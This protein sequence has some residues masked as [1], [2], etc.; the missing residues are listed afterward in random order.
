MHNINVNSQTAY[1]PSVEKFF[2]SFNYL[3]RPELRLKEMQFAFRGLSRKFEK[4]VTVNG[5]IVEVV[6]GEYNWK[7]IL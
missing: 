5:A 4:I 1:T 2:A 3:A 6:N 7:D